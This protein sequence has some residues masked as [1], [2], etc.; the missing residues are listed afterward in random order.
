MRRNLDEE[1]EIVKIRY[2]Q[3]QIELVEERLEELERIE[4][5][6][7]EH[8]AKYRAEQEKV[9][10]DVNFYLVSTLIILTIVALSSAFNLI[11][12]HFYT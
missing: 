3:A 5:E 10:K 2:E 1:L 12:L 9:N 6:S 11:Y 7:K 8:M 4:R